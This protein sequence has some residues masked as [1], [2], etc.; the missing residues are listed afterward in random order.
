[1]KKYISHSLFLLAFSIGGYALQAQTSQTP[2]TIPTPAQLR[3]S[4]A[5]YNSTTGGSSFTTG[6]TNHM[7]VPL[8]LTATQQKSMNSALYNFFNEKG[9]LTK[10]RWSDKIAY[11][12][13]TNSL[14]QKLVG[15]LGA[16][17]SPDQVNK[18]VA[19]KPASSV[20]RDP[21][22]TIFY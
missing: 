12:Q 9:G 11:Q 21:M 14:V 22:A 6:L 3:S 15:Q 19:M 20:T 13:Q 7:A 16:F 17:L 18:F 4:P 1:M 8:G 5:A 2:T 10:L